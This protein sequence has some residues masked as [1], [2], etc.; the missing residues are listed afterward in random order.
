[1]GPRAEVEYLGYSP[2]AAIETTAPACDIA[3]IRIS[4]SAAP[5]LRSQMASNDPAATV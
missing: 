5:P 3:V 4:K 1:M 2:L